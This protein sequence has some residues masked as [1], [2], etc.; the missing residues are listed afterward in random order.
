M[1]MS[2][3]PAFLD[4]LRSRVSLADLVGRKVTWDRKKSNQGRGDWWAPCPFHQ[5]KTASFHVLDREGRYYCFG[6]HAKGDAITFLREAENLSFMEAVEELARMA[7]VE[8]PARDPKAAEK[9]ETRAT[10]TEV[11][12]Q[13]V[14]HYR[15]QL[16]SA[17][18]AEARAYLARRG[19]DQEALARFEIGY[20][21][22]GWEGLRE[23][24]AA[25]GVEVERMLAAGLVRASDKGRAPYDTFRD[26][27]LFPI[28]DARG[29]AIAFG[30]RAM[31]P[32]DTAK[33][34]NS[35]DT[36][37]FDKSR[38]LYNHGPA[39]GACGK[40]AALI[41]AEGYMDVIA[42]VAAGFQG[43]VAPL[44]T[45]VTEHQLRML[46]KM[47]DE[48]IV[49]LDGDTAG[50]RAGERVM[51]LALPLME[52]GQ[53]LR[54]ALLPEGRD[55]DDVIREG[56][57]EAMQAVLD[58]ALPMVELMWRRETEARSLDSPERR[59]ALDRALRGRVAR[60][61]DP[62]I[63][64][65]YAHALRERRAA[66]FGF[67]RGGAARG[68]PG[69][70]WP[71]GGGAHRGRGF[72]AGYGAGRFAPPALPTQATRAAARAAAGT[73]PEH[74]REAVILATL[75]ACP[76]L[77]EDF[78]HVL[79]EMEFTGAGHAEIAAALLACDARATPTEVRADLGARL[80]RAPLERLMAPRH[81]TLSPGVRR[82]HD[83][84]VAR[85][86]LAGEFARLAA[87][88]GAA[89]EVAE[90]MEQLGRAERAPDPMVDPM[91]GPMP[92]LADAAAAWEPATDGPG[93]GAG[94]ARPDPWVEGDDDGALPDALTWRLA[95]AAR[96]SAAA[97]RTADGDRAEF[98]LAPN[99][100]RLDRREK[101]AFADLLREIGHDAGGDE[102][103]GKE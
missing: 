16:S 79:E 71:T 43:A 73:A 83:R 46:W 87:A 1:V 5:E 74:L 42:L 72:G 84:D 48:P 23:A 2:L 6:C 69:P 86:C 92:G 66:L 34:L 81:V 33:Y 58:G 63:R 21:P 52:A 51:D 54:F 59:A 88:R 80:G 24:L 39:W 93:D 62:S 45:A 102:A 10:L 98:D 100:V 13:A 15:M 82:A 56:G 94:A 32:S 85:A 36:E 4:D 99:G 55:P 40:G 91:P 50:L 103:G 22:P 12:E 8:M 31:D 61:A 95:E 96:A 65:H 37:L 41:V 90:A 20:A 68:A 17:K 97:E 76:A 19:L 9:A 67:D 25:K 101:S 60:I 30:G 14:R 77:I 28:R 35:P 7:G 57:A 44:G 11:M 38:T 64:A 26:R 49:A 89:R 75:I 3:S 70:G 47:H 78:A 18:A 29:R 27:I 53:S